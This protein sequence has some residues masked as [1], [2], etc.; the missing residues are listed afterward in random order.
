MRRRIVTLVAAAILL[1]LLAIV[2]LP[3]LLNEPLRRMMERNANSRL[4]GYTL[5]IGKLRIHPLSFS[6]DLLD[7][8]IVQASQPDPPMA[9]IPVFT[10]TVH[11]RALLHRRL[12]A[13]VLFDRPQ[14]HITLP[15]AR[16][17]VRDPVGVHERGWQEA[18]LEIYPLKVNLLRIRNGE[19]VYVD[20]GPFKPLELSQVNFRADN[21]RNV[22]SPDHVYPSDLHLDA[23]VFGQGRLA[24]DGAA[25]FL[26]VPHPGVKGTI[27]LDQ[28]RVDYFRPL[29]E[30]VHLTSDSGVFSAE[31]EVEYAPAVQSVHLTRVV[32]ERANL[33]YVQGATTAG[34]EQQLR[35]KVATEAKQAANE[36]RIRYRIDELLVRDSK[37]GFLNERARPPYLVFVEDTEI[38]LTN[39]SSQGAEG[40]A[41]LTLRGK[42]MGSGA[43]TV[44]A[45]FRPE[46]KT[47]DLA[48]DLKIE[49]TALPSMNNLLRAHG[50]F[51]VRA[52]RFSLFSEVRVQGG[53]IRG[54]VKPL[55]QD[56]D[57]Y[58]KRQDRH[59]PLMKRAYESVVGG[60][61]ELLENRVRNEV[62]TVAK[63]SGRVD[64]PN[65]STWQVAVRLIQNAFFQAILPGF[66]RAA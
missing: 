37:L 18:L 12:V 21:I 15:Q 7:L 1:I 50:N 40:P 3:T 65:T 22:W 4:E 30:K 56:M 17:E 43:S 25:N 16:E 38:R 51:D 53:Q 64:N 19:V 63:L 47:V 66:E 20:R 46:A 10:A 48:V 36:P 54:Y 61:S 62:A 23:M 31:G 55:F 9:R 26:A 42:F 34:R 11:W 60:V 28:V 52:G 33:Q 6:L 59:K 14:L 13:D 27:A 35:Q 44:S 57:V 45:R 2:L 5:Q 32:L 39:L 24:V 49:N 29:L 41:R 58:D 8:V